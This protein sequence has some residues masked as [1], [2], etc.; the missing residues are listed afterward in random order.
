MNILYEKHYKVDLLRL[1]KFSSK[2][3]ANAE[4]LN[5]NSELP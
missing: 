2:L 5:V 4:F 3:N 1:A